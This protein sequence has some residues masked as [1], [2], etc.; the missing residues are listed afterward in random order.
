MN[1][2]DALLMFEFPYDRKAAEFSLDALQADD[3]TDHA[4][5]VPTLPIRTRFLADRPTPD[6]WPV[7]D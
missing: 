5:E 3:V 6:D 1:A 2:N 4:G 7:Y